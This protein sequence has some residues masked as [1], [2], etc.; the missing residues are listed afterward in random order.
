MTEE[1]LNY[2]VFI[3]FFKTFAQAGLE[4]MGFEDPMMIELEHLTE[5]NNQIFYISDAI[6]LDMLFISKG[7]N[8]MFG[9][10][11]EKVPQGFFLTTT[12]PEDFRRHQL[13]RAHLLSQAQKLYIQKSGTRIISTNVRA[14]KPDGSCFHLLYQANLIYSKVPYESVFL[15]LVITDISEFEKMPK[16]FHYYSGD[17]RRFFRFPDEE[18]LM[19][20]NI[21][22]HSE[23][24]IIEL[25]EEGLSSKEIAQKLC[26]SVHTIN[27]HRTNILKKSGKST[28]SDVI[29]DLKATGLL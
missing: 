9:I 6:L 5:R 16:S 1:N 18:L 23:F 4:G 12:I 8:T 28:I 19:I 27:T 25:I 2:S 20:G 24:N 10:K 15:I 29:R 3:E 17:D 22:S 21:F 26:R 14:R 11:Q 13:A 7:V